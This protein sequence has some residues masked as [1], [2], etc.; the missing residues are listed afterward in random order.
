MPRPALT[1]PLLA[2]VLTASGCGRAAS[3]S[4]D[5][6]GSAR[7]DAGLPD[8]SAPRADAAVADA[9]PDAGPPDAELTRDAE[10]SPDVTAPADAG[11]GPTFTTDVFPMMEATGCSRVGCHGSLRAQGGIAVYLPDALSAYADLFERPS[12][13]E[14]R[15]LVQPGVPEESVLFT[16]G[17]DANIPAGDLT[18]EGLALMEAWI[19]AGAPLGPEVTPPERPEPATCSLAELPGTPPLPSACMP[20]CAAETWQAVVDCRRDPDVAGCQARVLAADPTP[21]GTLDFGP[22]LGTTPLTCD[23]CLDFQ[24]ESCFVELCRAQYLTFA[25]CRALDADPAACQAEVRQVFACSSSTPAF[26]ACQ[27]ARDEAC[28]AR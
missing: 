20:R 22:E 10:V 3:A 17:R 4:L 23:A 5:D 16:H 27:A 11:T 19:R 18:P 26:R 21:A 8:T 15:L 24:T 28:V 1:F 7:A 9:S 13:R 14:P 6:T 25:R 2:L 12:I